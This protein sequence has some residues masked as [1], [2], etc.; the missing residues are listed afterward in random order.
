MRILILV[1]VTLCYFTIS[2]LG[3]EK[4]NNDNTLSSLISAAVEHNENLLAGKARV[5]SVKAFNSQLTT[6]PNPVL[7]ISNAANGVSQTIPNL[8][9]LDAKG[10]MASYAT[11]EAELTYMMEEQAIAQAVVN[12]YYGYILARHKVEVIK[13][14]QSSLQGFAIQINSKFE[15]GQATILDKLKIDYELALTTKDLESSYQELAITRAT[16]SNLTRLSEASISVNGDFSVPPMQEEHTLNLDNNVDMRLASTTIKRLDAAI[17]SYNLFPEFTLSAGNDNVQNMTT[18]GVSLPLPVWDH[19]QNTVTGSKAALKEGELRY[20][21]TKYRVTLELQNLY[22]Q[23]QLA[24]NQLNLYEKY[25][26]KQRANDA[27]YTAQTQYQANQ[28]TTLDY[29]DSLRS[30]RS[31]ELDYWQNKY[32]QNIAYS[33]IEMMLGHKFWQSQQDNGGKK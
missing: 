26:I 9:V 30:Y 32:N 20:Q 10:K 15:V 11:Q 17:G 21:A 24:T 1:M 6:L 4:E 18:F 31:S 7:N 8:S 25:K 23:Y 22:R 28:I 29:L 2:A 3:A 12:N 27:R 5:E 19:G 13:E 33:N 16:L 14:L